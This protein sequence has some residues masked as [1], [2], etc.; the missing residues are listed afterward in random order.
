MTKK[1]VKKLVNFEGSCYSNEPTE[2]YDKRGKKSQYYHI[3]P[4]YHSTEN[5]VFGIEDSRKRMDFLKR[6]KP[7]KYDPALTLKEYGSQLARC[8]I[9]ID[10]NLKE[11][12]KRKRKC[13]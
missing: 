3:N 1:E 11:L 5:L 13:E 2:K 6:N 4:A 9:T 12:E 10:D 8:E 7:D